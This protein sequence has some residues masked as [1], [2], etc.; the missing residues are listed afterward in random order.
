MSRILFV[1]SRLPWPTDSGRKVS[2]WHYCRGLAAR[3]HSVS[4]FVFPEWD[5]P[6]SEAGK[7]DFIDRVYFAER[8][9]KGEKLIGI[10]GNGNYGW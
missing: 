4:L 7:P 10:V 9:G 3:G 1:T 8:I 6:R 2:L 5:Q